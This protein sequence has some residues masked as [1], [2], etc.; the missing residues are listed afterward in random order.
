MGQKLRRREHAEKL[1]QG[2]VRPPT[3]LDFSRKTEYC[4]RLLS[5]QRGR[6]GSHR[7][8]AETGRAVKESRKI[9]DGVSLLRESGSLTE[10]YRVFC[11]RKPP[12]R[13]QSD[14]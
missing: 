4:Y 12:R 10:Y 7:R 8:R 5:G 13:A 9:K 11:Q 1:V 3:H 14:F 6:D 2:S